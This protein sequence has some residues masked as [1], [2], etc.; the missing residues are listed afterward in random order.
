MGSAM[1]GVSGMPVPRAMHQVSITK[2]KQTL[3]A[4]EFWAMSKMRR[5]RSR[6]SLLRGI[7]R[8]QPSTSLHSHLY[9]P[10][11]ALYCP[12]S[13]MH[14][15]LN[16]PRLS[17]LYLGSGKLERAC[18]TCPYGVLARNHPVVR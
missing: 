14:L 7:S 3:L 16:T 18:S 5:R 4:S 12:K 15:G 6:V 10:P 17:P 2:K 8:C 13:M 11:F 9:G 1:A